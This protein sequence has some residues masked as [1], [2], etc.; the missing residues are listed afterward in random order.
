MREELADL[1]ARALAE[2]EAAPDLDGLEVWRISILGTRGRLR[3]LQRGL[4]GLP[5]A[6]SA[7]L[8]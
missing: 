7:G 4:G 5:P 1:Q 2:L 3:E 6:E 8:A